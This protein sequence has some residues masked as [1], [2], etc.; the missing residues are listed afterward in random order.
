MGIIAYGVDVG[1]TNEVYQARLL[2]DAVRDH[3][4]WPG[5]PYLAAAVWKREE[6][7][8]EAGNTR[9]WDHWH[10]PLVRPLNEWLREH[11][12]APHH[13]PHTGPPGPVGPGGEPG[14]AC[15]T[16]PEPGAAALFGAGVVLVAIWAWL[17]KPGLI[18]GG[19]P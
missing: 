16:V 15:G 17:R 10:K 9:R 4:P 1:P 8:A 12:A 3:L 19:T 13:V 7:I 18:E 11:E 5:T 6:D 14:A 2:E